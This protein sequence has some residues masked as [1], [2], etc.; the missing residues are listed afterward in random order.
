VGGEVCRP[1]K[2]D[3]GTARLRRWLWR[4][5]WLPRVEY[6]GFDGVRARQGA[7]KDYF[8]EPDLRYLTDL[9]PSGLLAGSGRVP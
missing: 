7:W 6:S 1:R 2:R 4:H 8:S 3:R 5:G 9:Y